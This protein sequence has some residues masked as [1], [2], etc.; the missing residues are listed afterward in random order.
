MEPRGIVVKEA[1]GFQD[2]ILEAKNK[3]RFDSTYK[4]R[5]VQH[6]VWVLED[7]CSCNSWRVHTWIPDP[8]DQ[9]YTYL[10][11]TYTQYSSRPIASTQRKHMETHGT[12]NE[13]P[14]GRH[15]CNLKNIV[16]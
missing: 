4:Q 15:A 2:L 6:Q 3:G 11:H 8:F 9:Q 10:Y 13:L 7:F 5:E 12:P 1:E 16:M 14:V